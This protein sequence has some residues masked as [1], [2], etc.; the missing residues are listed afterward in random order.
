M[1]NDSTMNF[2][3]DISQLK[4]AMQEAGRAIRLANSEFKAATAGMQDW[5]SSADGLQAKLKQLASVLGS[6]KSQL[7]LM[8][9]ELEKTAKAYGENSAEADRVRIK[10]NNQKAAVANTE[11]QIESYTQKL[12]GVKQASEQVGELSKLD[13][14]KQRIRELEGQL[15]SL[16]AEYASLQL[17]ERD[18]TQESEK[19]AREISQL[20]GELKDAKTDL[21]NAEKAADELDQSLEEVEDSSGKAGEGFTV[22]KGALSSLLADGIRAAANGLKNLA[23]ETFD[24]GVNFESSMSNVAALSGA[25]GEDLEKLESTAK[26]FGAS[27]VFS[28]GEA[29]DALGYMA[30]AGWDANQSSSALGGVLNLAA[31]S[32]MDLAA[33]SDMV[34]DYLSAFS[35]EASD[36]AKFA[37]ELAYA[38]ANS[39]TSATQLGEAFKNCAANLNA[40]GQDVETTTSLLASMANQGLKG[41]EAG[42]ALTAIMRDLTA[43]MKDG[44]IIIGET[45]VQVQDAN[46]NYRDLTDIL[47]DVNK[48]TQGMGKA[49]KAAA[50]RSTFTADSIKGLNLIL[51]DGVDK[52]AKFEESLRNCDGAAQDMADTMNDN[53]S[54]SLKMLRSNVEDKMIKVFDAA[55]PKIKSAINSLSRALNEVDWNSVAEKVGNFA[56][57]VVEVF[58][59]ILSNSGAVSSALGTIGTVI[60]TMYVADKLS[61]FKT[62]LL[63]LIPALA[64]LTTATE[65]ATTATNFLAI[66]Q[67]ALPFLAL[68]AGALAVVGA[69]EL[70]NK[71]Q[72]QAIRDQHA[73]TD[74]QQKYIDAANTSRSR[75][76]ELNKS[77]K[78]S[79]GKINSESNYLNGL[80]EEYNSL[81]DSNGKVKKGYEDR[82]DFILTT[83]AN[84]LGV[85]RSEIDKNIGK[86]GKLKKSI[87]ELIEVQRAQAML[88]ANNEAYQEATQNRE[89]EQQTYIKNL[90]TLDKKQAEYNETRQ[91][92][93]RVEEKYNQLS[94]DN[95]LTAIAYKHS[96]DDVIIANDE[97]KNKYEEASE[98]VKKSEETLDSY[99]K[100]IKDQE[101]LS[102]A[103]MSGNT[104]KIQKAMAQQQ[105]AFT[106]AE[107]GTVESLEKQAQDYTDY[108]FKLLAISKDGSGRVTKADLSAAKYR[109]DAANKEVEKAKGAAA[110][111]Y[112]NVGDAEAKGLASTAP[113]HKKAAATNK[114]AAL[115]GGKDKGEFKRQSKASGKSGAKALG[116]TA[117]E[118]KKAGQKTKKAA[119]QGSNAKAE[120]GKQGDQGGVSYAK[121]LAAT[122][123]KSKRAGGVLKNASVSGA[124]GVAAMGK[125]G[126]QGGGA[127]ASGVASKKGAANKSGK[128][129]ASSSVSGASTGEAGMYTQGVNAGDGYA[130]GV[131][132]KVSAAAS[133]AAAVVKA[134]LAAARKAQD[135]HSPSKVTFRFGQYFTQGYINGIASQEK[136]LQKLVSSLVGN[137]IKN[138]KT[139]SQFGFAEAGQTAST[140]FADAFSARSTYLMNRVTYQNEQNLK[141]FDNQTAKMQA[142]QAKRNAAIQKRNNAQV[143]KLETARNRERV[144]LERERDRT[145][146]DIEK[147]RDRKVAELEK[148]RDQRVK[149]LEKKRAKLKKAADKQK[150][151]QSIKAIKAQ[152]AK[153]IKETKA[154]ASKQIKEAKNNTAKQIKANNANYAKRI[155][156]EQAAGK[157]E[158]A[159]SNKEYNKRLA[160]QNSQKEAYQ[161]ASSEMLSQLQ[162]ALSEYQSKAQQLIDDTINGITDKYTELYNDLMNKQESLIDRMQSA[163]DLFDISGAGVMTVNDLKEQ[164]KAIN[165]YASKLEK[166]K[167]KVSQE[168]F[169]QISSYDMTEGS[170]FMD[171]LLSMSTKDLNAYNKAYTDKMKAAQAAGEKIYKADFDKIAKNYKADIDK[172]FKT[173]P[174]QL[175][176]LGLQAMKG[177]TSG[178]TRNTD[179]MSKAIKKFVNQ[180][181][182]EFKTALK[183][184]SPSRVTA[185]IGMFAGEGVADGLLDTVKAV[186][187]AAQRIAG[188][189]TSPLGDITG[190]VSGIRAAVRPSGGSVYNSQVINNYNLVQN[191]TSPRSLSALETYQAR[192]RQI[193]MVKAATQR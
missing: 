12:E 147:A 38:Q 80:R 155:K 49:E 192:R 42:T 33:A 153:E 127:Y 136:S 129:L 99:N 140:A 173:L 119:L 45:A 165:D 110:K 91:A 190:D 141:V 93:A 120:M 18:T 179:Y 43:K 14:Q 94:K 11:K 181:V 36:S 62:N 47:K 175:Q 51:N 102:S 157:K 61:T 26:E 40:A 74:E 144:K 166:I 64:N 161:A 82:A 3:A 48:A 84:A 21:G 77:R 107:Q 171:R 115:E 44:K 17:E 69:L 5:G 19:L 139:L 146:A 104:K 15:D 20:S 23:K 96:Q 53:V 164:T 52:A 87:T 185:S 55:A 112:K 126:G 183:I 156:A 113:A 50:L 131:K 65:G 16:K 78:E 7:S 178:L 168:L 182:K 35:L 130:R 29:A 59:F 9:Q 57:T 75:I 71:Q 68:A 184:K 70:Y 134:A 100:T 98:A 66:A 152:S 142:E 121:R 97:A 176:A 137:V 108:Y 170:A 123:S 73:F 88:D 30:L 148:S 85:E 154:S 111:A 159:A 34:T 27:T 31:A 4:A 46:G 186:Q 41:S 90:E 72:E 193:A 177:F 63:N 116:A 89:K 24:V 103:V 67:A 188:A 160:I 117:P 191:N 128:T 32:G 118:H 114:K 10:I 25:T 158:L 187:S 76:D 163:G 149:A 39:N 172:A 122:S 162:E 106:T 167:G 81:I 124:A 95:L 1:P 133:A 83:L 151:T 138:L 105:F 79:I 86:N 92:A 28:A 13:Q 37:D 174:S 54:G 109:M 189:V 60:A 8:E 150:V 132:S 58:K 2:R 169:D 22:L 145:V 125:T 56:E 143:K 180:M 6:Q 101:T 135:S